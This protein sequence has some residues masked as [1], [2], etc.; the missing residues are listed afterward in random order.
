MST[1]PSSDLEV[2]AADER[3]RLHSSIVEFKSR[4]REKL[5]VTQSARRHVL[6]GSGM[7]ALVG[8]VL[9]YGFA[10]IFTAVKSLRSVAAGE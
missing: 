2:R 10:G 3:R 8:L 6:L 7:A 1:L 9:G 5:D 4:A